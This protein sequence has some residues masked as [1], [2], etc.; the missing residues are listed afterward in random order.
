M[1]IP[2]RGEK[3]LVDRTGLFGAVWGDC[4]SGCLGGLGCV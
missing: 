4:C 3:L 1:G 2:I